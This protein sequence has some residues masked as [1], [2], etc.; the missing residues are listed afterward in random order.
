MLKKIFNCPWPLGYCAL[1]RHSPRQ[2]SMTPVPW[3]WWTPR[4][5]RGNEGLYRALTRAR[6]KKDAT[7]KIE[8]GVLNIAGTHQT[9][10]ILWNS[11]R[12]NKKRGK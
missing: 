9:W 12:V 6:A 2:V 5:L 7:G 1:S 11:F 4:A 10:P 8:Y 3:T